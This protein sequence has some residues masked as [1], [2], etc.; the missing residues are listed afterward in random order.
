MRVAGQVHYMIEQG[1]AARRVQTVWNGID[2]S[3]FAYQG[4]C[5]NGSV[6]TVARLSP[7]KDIGN[8]LRTARQVVDADGETRF[9]IA[10]DGPCRDDLP[11]LATELKLTNHVEFLGEVRDV[12]ALWP[13]RVF[14]LPSLSEG[15]SLTLLE[16]MVGSA[17]CDDR[18]WRQSGS[19]GRWCYGR[20][21]PAGDPRRLPRR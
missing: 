15:V 5:K 10:G 13:A 7:E 19:C 20:A 12:P 14:V 18:G 1:I 2:L 8:L 11:R 9:E 4:P 16:A 6:V 3:R 21:R 17:S